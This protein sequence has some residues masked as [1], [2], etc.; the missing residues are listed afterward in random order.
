MR[1]ARNEMSDD[2]LDVE[3]LMGDI[4]RLIDASKLAGGRTLLRF[5]YIDLVC[6]LHKGF[7]NQG[8]MSKVV[9]PIGWDSSEWSVEKA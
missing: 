8:V 5:K 4:Q 3:L 9:V 6:I 7:G 1:W 2:E